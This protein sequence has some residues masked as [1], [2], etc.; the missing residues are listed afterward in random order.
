M[1][2][3]ERQEKDKE[4]R[5]FLLKFD[6][7]RETLDGAITEEDID[8]EIC[9]R[10]QDGVNDEYLVDGALLT[11]T[12]AKW[13]SFDLPSGGS[14]EIDGHS[15]KMMT[16]EPTTHLHV[17]EN[18][19]SDNGLC[20]ATIADTVQEGN[21]YPFPCN[22][23]EAATLE[24]EK[25]IIANK[26]ECQRRGV[27]KYL[28]DLEEEWE[29]INFGVSYAQ[30]PYNDA[31]VPGSVGASNI[32]EPGGRL[33]SELKAGITMTSVLFCR[34]GG[35]I[36]PLTSGQRLSILLY[37][38]RQNLTDDELQE[39]GFLFQTGN[40]L[41]RTKIFNYLFPMLYLDGSSYGETELMRHID[42]MNNRE[43][44]IP[45]AA[46]RYVNA[47]NKCGINNA[48]Y[49]VEQMIEILRW[50]QQKIDKTFD[51]CRELS[52][53]TG[54]IMSP[55][56]ALAVIGA[57]GT[58]SYDTNRKVRSEYGGGNGPQHDFAIDTENG[59]NVIVEKLGSY[60]IY[61]DE[62]K[63]VARNA[64]KTDFF[65]PYIWGETPKFGRNMAGYYASDPTWPDVVEEKYQKYSREEEDDDRD[66]MHDYEMLLM[67]Y[68]KE[69][70]ENKDTVQ[71]EFV[72]KNGS[73]I[74]EI[75]D[76][77]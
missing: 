17:M 35:F 32:L 11:C 34:H 13:G 48:Q 59:L 73:V 55:Y 47:L 7:A 15:E 37:K 69:L 74:A 60:I 8:A 26:D 38:D 18:P 22:C 64:G 56:F 61:G 50:D 52:L 40:E 5:Q 76:K 45:H 16:G 65:V 27:C 42:I 2:D 28:M 70:I 31:S 41:T 43:D 19:M 49:T 72:Y 62:Y 63:N 67:G 21:I 68:D 71:Y 58:G 46:E 36:Y 6:L 10:L 77:K 53:E 3:K 39:L 66:Y 23:R 1:D 9:K 24:Q 51:A 14:I 20:H 4:N 29:N 25:D 54:I 44:K 12:R 75:K 57:E 30:F 33:M